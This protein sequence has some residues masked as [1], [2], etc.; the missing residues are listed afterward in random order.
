MGRGGDWVRRVAMRERS[1]EESGA[2][3]G[4]ADRV[5][6]ALRVGGMLDDSH[7]CCRWVS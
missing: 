4:R 5:L 3:A 1:E 6:D 7:D 2:R